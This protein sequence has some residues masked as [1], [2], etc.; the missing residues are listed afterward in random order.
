ML[1]VECLDAASGKTL[2]RAPRLNIT[3]T[4]APFVLDGVEYLLGISTNNS[5]MQLVAI[6]M[7][8]GRLLWP[9]TGT[10]QNPNTTGTPASIASRTWRPDR[11]SR[12]G[13]PLTS[14]ATPVS[15]ATAIVRSRSSAFSGRCPISRPVGW[16]RQ[17]TAGCRIASV[18]RA[19]SSRRGARWPAVERELHPLELGQH[20]VGGVE[21]AVVADVALD[22]AQDPERRQALVG[23]G[24]LLRLPPQGVAV[25][26]G[27]TL[28]FG[29]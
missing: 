25:K 15:S 10:P 14:S 22:T 24:D 19:V 20:V 1:A 21:T 28:T 11:S 13:R 8:T 7:G 17:R 23:C 3:I 29:V 26:P 16:L 18:T 6:D 9:S 2:W 4:S 5:T 27:T 12:F